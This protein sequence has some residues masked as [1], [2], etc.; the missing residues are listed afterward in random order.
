MRRERADAEEIGAQQGG[1]GRERRNGSGTITRMAGDAGDPAG[2]RPAHGA[3]SRHPPPPTSAGRQQQ[4]AAHMAQ[5][6]ATG[7]A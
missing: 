7:D 6:P 4:R 3:E 1:S 5:V 2:S